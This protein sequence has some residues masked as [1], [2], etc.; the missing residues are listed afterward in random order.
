MESEQIPPLYFIKIQN[1]TNG[2]IVGNI[3]W[4]NFFPNVSRHSLSITEPAKNPETIINK[5][6]WNE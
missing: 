1:I 3:N 4:T 2:I 5:G 6:I